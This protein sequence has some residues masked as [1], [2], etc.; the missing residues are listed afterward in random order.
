M[1]GGASAP[2]ERATADKADVMLIISGA[3]E[4]EDAAGE[5]EARGPKEQRKRKSAGERQSAGAQGNAAESVLPASASARGEG[6][7]PGF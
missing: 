6:K 1:V 4:K 2:V 5:G 7:A 3:R